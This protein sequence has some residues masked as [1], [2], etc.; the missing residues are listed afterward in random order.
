MRR[1][2]TGWVAAGLLLAVAGCAATGPSAGRAA[3]AEGRLRARRSIAVEAYEACRRSV[4]NVGVTRQDPKDPKVT[5]FER[6][7]GVVLS[8][9]GYVL[10]NAHSL[11]NGGQSAAGLQGG[12]DHPARVVALDDRRDLAI[13]K[14]EPDEPL[15]PIVLGH[16]RDLLIGEP[17]VCLGNPF[18]MGLSV[19]SGIVS[20]VGRATQSDYTFHP[21]MI[22]TDAS[23]NPG[24]SGGPLVNALGE[25]VGLSTTTKLGANNI[26]FAIPVDRIREALPEMLDP[27]GRGGFVLGMEVAADGPARVTAVA[28][29]SPA[30]A[31]G[32]RAGDLVV[33]VG[34]ASTCSGL[35]VDLAL[36]GVR[37]GEPLILRVLRGGRFLDLT[38]HPTAIEPL[39]PVAAADLEPGLTREM[40]TGQ[41]DALPD[42]AALK[43]AETAKAD[44]FD[45]GPGQ[46]K[47]GFALRFTGYLDVPA[48][49]VYGFY[50]AS[51]DGS[52]LWIGDRLVVDNDGLH[53]AAERR[54]FIPLRAGKHPITV[55]YFERGGEESLKVSWEGPGLL[56]QP[57]PASALFRPKQAG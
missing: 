26:G 19:S 2:G 5:H 16:S 34:G 8:A 30:Q 10:T 53:P 51:D 47:D 21:D 57:I 6:G 40:Y 45:L 18:G 38:A 35:D 29:G 56:K 39:A 3:G 50:T 15:R 55:A 41:W 14:I 48:D 27:E 22:Q 13:L 33:R 46:G 32:L 37:G 11:R 49:G 25:M 4:V 12:K 23:T 31:A 44:A 24:N 52:R 7:S 54:G 36:L 20:A 1:T 9:S 42:F 17:V 28:E 43:P